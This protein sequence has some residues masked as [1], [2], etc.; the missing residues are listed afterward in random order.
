ISGPGILPFGLL[1]ERV[2]KVIA[3]FPALYQILPISAYVTDQTGAAVDILADVSWLSEEH[4]PLLR[5]AH[6]FRRELGAQTSVPT[7][8]IFGYGLK[9]IT[10]IQIQRMPA[11][12]WAKVDFAHN[13]EGDTDV[14]T[15]SAV[16]AGSEIH[17]VQQ[18]HGSLY[19]DNDVKM[20]LKLELT[21]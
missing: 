2:R 21:R 19:V 13:D 14:P 18:H 3:T 15:T 1:G 10:E 20:R 7:V 9:T 5:D 16:L 4:R 12:Q 6:R 17:P 8:S 11:G